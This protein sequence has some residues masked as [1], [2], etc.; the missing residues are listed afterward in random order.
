M[1]SAALRPREPDFFHSQSLA[2]YVRPAVNDSSLC[3]VVL[4]AGQQQG[5][6]SLPGFVMKTEHALRPSARSASVGVQSLAKRLAAGLP[7][8]RVIQV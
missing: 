1:G 5:R 3:F 8:V 4:Q 7:G 2:D 6:L